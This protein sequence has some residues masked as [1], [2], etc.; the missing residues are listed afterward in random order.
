MTLT[1]FGSLDDG[2]RSMMV[3]SFAGS[4][5]DFGVVMLWKE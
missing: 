3:V 2:S 1:H 4:P 5:I